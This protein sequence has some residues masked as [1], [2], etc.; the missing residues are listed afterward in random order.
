MHD[1]AAS[2]QDVGRAN[3]QTS[4]FMRL[5]RFAATLKENKMLNF[6]LGRNAQLLR[7]YDIAL[8]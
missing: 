8:W 3:Y 5:V 1:A 4:L 6:I 7:I 2:V